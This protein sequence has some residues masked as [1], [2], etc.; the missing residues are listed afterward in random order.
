MLYDKYKYNYWTLITTK[1]L[2]HF[3]HKITYRRSKKKADIT[4]SI[5]FWLGTFE[6][7]IVYKLPEASHSLIQYISYKRVSVV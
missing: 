6:L 5:G 1:I 7:N 2:K 3:P 4:I